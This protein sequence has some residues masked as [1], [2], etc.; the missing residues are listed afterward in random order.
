MLIQSHPYDE[1]L[2]A[3]VAPLFEMSE[4]AAVT[5]VS[6]PVEFGGKHYLL[7]LSELGAVDRRGLSRRVGSLAA[8][9]DDIPR[10]LDRL[11][12]GF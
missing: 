5:R 1:G 12:T 4:A 2:T 9:E 10:A 3:L 7:T 6:L 11:F 8:R